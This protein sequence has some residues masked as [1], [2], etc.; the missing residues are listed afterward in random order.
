MVGDQH[1]GS[2]RRRVPLGTARP[3]GVVLAPMGL[4]PHYMRRA[5]M[6]R[7]AT[8]GHTEM[9]MDRE[10]ALERYLPLRP[11]EDQGLI[12]TA[13]RRRAPDAGDERRNYYRLKP[14]GLRVARA[15][16]RRMEA[17]TRAARLGGLLE[18]SPT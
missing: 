16:A 1:A 14:L 11:V 9:G 3:T 5:Y 13:E 12:G 10:R 6:R 7:T 17:L 4:D 15:E 2:C 8:W 18:A